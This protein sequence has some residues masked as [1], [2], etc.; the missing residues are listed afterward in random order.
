SSG[1]RSGAADFTEEQRHL[2]RR[3]SSVE[4]R[5]PPREE[6]AATQPGI[7]REGAGHHPAPQQP[8][9]GATATSRRHCT[10]LQ[11]TS[12]PS[13]RRHC[14]SLQAMLTPTSRGRRTNLQAAPTLA[15]RGAPH[16]P[17]LPP[18]RKVHRNCA[19][20]PTTLTRKAQARSNRRRSPQP[21]PRGDKEEQDDA[22]EKGKSS[23]LSPMPGKARSRRWRDGGEESAGGKERRSTGGVSICWQGY[24]MNRNPRPRLIAGNGGIRKGESD[25]E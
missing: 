5:P 14:S 24:S 11:A 22:L 4:S 23:G 3:C 1:L 7:A 6:A 13:S 12:T 25:A 18:L 10:S 9:G 16:A 15:Y 2:T 19:V 21:L 8:P 20:C 17:R